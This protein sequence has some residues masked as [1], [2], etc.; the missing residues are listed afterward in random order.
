MRESM[1]GGE[2]DISIL[3]VTYIYTQAKK[4]HNPLV[5]ALRVKTK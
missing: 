2:I 3:A 4:S 1:E 5:N